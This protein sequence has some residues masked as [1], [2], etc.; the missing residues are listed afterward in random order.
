M[1]EEERRFFTASDPLGFILFARNIESPDQVR[2][3]TAAL[4]DTVG[5]DAPILIDQEGGRVRRLR[6]P[7]W[8]DAPAMLPFGVLHARDPDAAVRALRLNIGL[9][10]AE[11]RGLGVDVDCAPVL[12]VPAPG[13]HDIIGDRAFSDDPAVVAALGR[14]VMDAFLENGVY[15]VIKHIPGHGRAM[16]DS[17]FDLPV[18]DASKAELESRDFVPFRALADAPFAMTAHI[19]YTAL[20]AARPATTSAAVI[21]GVIRGALGY[22]GLLMTDDLSMKALTG[23]FEDRASDSLE[24]GCDLVLHCNGIMDEMR[25]VVAGCRPLDDAAQVRWARVQTQRS[26]TP[27]VLVVAEAEAELARLL[28]TGQG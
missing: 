24:A 28:L 21:D 10:A 12:D 26:A 2:A 5:R 23:R 15:P 20:D 17:H 6:P 1:S 3:L 27:P 14:V 11:L 19:V 22:D 4:R 18:V 25:A 8:R 16:A 7:L 13:A 9:M